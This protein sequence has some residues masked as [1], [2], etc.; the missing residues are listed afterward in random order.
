MS[1]YIVCIIYYYNFKLN[2]IDYSNPGV[3]VVWRQGWEHKTTGKLG[4]VWTAKL[5]R[6]KPG[7]PE[8]LRGMI[9]VSR[10]PDGKAGTAVPSRG[11]SWT[12]RLPQSKD[13]LKATPGQL[14]YITRQP[15]CGYKYGTTISSSLDRRP[16]RGKVGGKKNI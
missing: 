8:I 11:R 14:Q 2:P 10:L 3:P 13:H 7:M 6:V 1:S 5:Q 16:P 15:L 4:H 9:K 12:Q